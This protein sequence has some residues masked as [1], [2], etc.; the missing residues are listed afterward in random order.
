MEGAIP[1]EAAIGQPEELEDAIDGVASGLVDDARAAGGVLGKASGAVA[2]VA[3][4]WAVAAEGCVQ[5]TYGGD[6]GLGDPH[7]DRVLLQPAGQQMH[8]QAQALACACGRLQED[9]AMLLLQA[10]DGSQM[11]VDFQMA[12]EALQPLQGALLAR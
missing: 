5:A 10:V 4:G 11:R 6:G 1:F 12:Q 9:N 3:R 8:G 7:V 2:N